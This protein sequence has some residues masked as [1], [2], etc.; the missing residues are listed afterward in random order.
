MRTVA[1]DDAV[2][3]IFSKGCMATPWTNFLWPS[4]VYTFP[5]LLLLTCHTMAVPSRDPDTRYD[6]SEDQHR[7]MTSPTWPRSCLGWPQRII[8]S[9]LP[10]ST[11]TDL[12]DQTITIWSS[13]PLA[14]N[15][16]FGEN[17]TQFTV[18]WCPPAKSYKYDGSALKLPSD[19]PPT[20]LPV[21]QLSIS[22]LSGRACAYLDLLSR[23]FL[24]SQNLMPESSKVT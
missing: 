23:D 19:A 13:E 6:E 16:P 21:A 17:R 22:C 20:C 2:A 3:T 12:R 7:S 24:S 8:S 1:S 11:G 15:W 4:R 5:N 10:N 9:T 14:R 18:F